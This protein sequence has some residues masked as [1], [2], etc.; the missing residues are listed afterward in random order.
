MSPNW[1]QI[2]AQSEEVERANAA[3]EA[4]QEREYQKQIDE[5]VD[6]ARTKEPPLR[7]RIPRYFPGVKK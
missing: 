5:A 4:A 6:E 2:I 7:E 1:A 3:E